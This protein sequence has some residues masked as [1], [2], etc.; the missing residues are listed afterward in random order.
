MIG[1][2]NTKVWVLTDGKTG[3]ENQSLGLAAALKVEPSVKFVAPKFPWSKLPPSLWLS[4]I[5]FADPDGDQLIPPWPEIV[6][7]AGRQ[8]VAPALAIKSA[9]G[10]RTFCIQVQDPVSRRNQFDVIAAPRHDGISGENIVETAG[11]LTG[12]TQA[13]LDNA[14]DRFSGT[15]ATIPK[16]L[17]AVLIGGS[18]GRYRMTEQATIRLSEGLKRLSAE[19]K[20]G[21]AITTSR[22]T[23]KEIEALLRKVLTGASTWIWNGEGENPYLGLLALADAI[24]VTADSVSMISEACSTGK[25]VYIAALEGGSVKL[26]RFHRHLSDRGMTRVFDGTLRSWTYDPLRDTELVAEE[27]ADRYATFASTPT[28]P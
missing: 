12:I 11:A 13:V 2:A 19:Q 18:N 10:G 9:S 14:S 17:V 25:P 15:L 7:A 22:R 24:V 23:G 5:R 28:A 16:P 26:N 3:H 6:I 20:A 27:V 21:L 8:T 4:P 1:L